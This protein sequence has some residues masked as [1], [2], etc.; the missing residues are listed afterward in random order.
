MQNLDLQNKHLLSKWLLKFYNEDDIWQE[1]LRNKYIKDKTLS[2]VTKKPGDSH[3]RM[4]LLGVK[5][6]FMSLA[7]FNLGDGTQ[8]RF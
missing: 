4:G 3:F 2:R 6:Q 1:L 5:E 7:K 8:I